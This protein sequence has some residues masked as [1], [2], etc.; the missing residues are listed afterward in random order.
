MRLNAIVAGVGLTRFGKHLERSQKWLA[1]EAARMA[2]ADA[3]LQVADIEAAY[4]GNC[5]AGIVTGQESIRGQ[6][7]L[8]GLGLRSI[9]ILNIENACGSSATALNQACAMVSAGYHDVVLVVGFE[10]LY[11]VDKAIS[12]AAF[13]GAVDVEERDRFIAEHAT[14]QPDADGKP[15]SLFT[16]FYGVL[17][18]SYMAKRDASIEHF[19]MVAAKN[20]FHGSLN[21]N[22]QFTNVMT[23]EAVL[24]Q[25]VV[26]D[27]LTRPMIC[28]LADGGSAAVV[29]SE[30]KARQMGISKPV[31]VLSSVV[32]SYFDHP[33]DAAENVTSIAIAE[34]YHDAGVAPADLDL[35][36][37]HDSSAVTELLTYEHL[38]LAKPEDC[39]RLL[40]DGDTRL[41]GRIPVN[42]S[43]GLLR[44]GHPVGATGLAQVAEITLQLQQR[45]GKRQVANARV[46]LCHNGG[47]NIRGEVAAMNITILAR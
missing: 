32:R 14:P 36:E 42:T 23:V 40:V 45:A 41:G 11:H 25:P 16:D 8:S 17:A 4:V 30:R 22:A 29:V 20:S 7:V 13:S 1:G 37:L 3:G 12:Y 2:I 43:G 21:P 39:L 46:G 24:A 33:V 10:K 44:K 9:P 27:P 18:R 15:R 31:R 5:A 34:A 19:A 26:S 35:V 38:Q 6:V 47:G 28:P